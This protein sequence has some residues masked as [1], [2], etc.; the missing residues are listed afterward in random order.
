M[1]SPLISV[2]I[3]IHNC[4]KYL[5]ECLDSVVS[6]TLKDIEIIIVDDASTDASGQTADRYAESDARFRVI[7]LTES[8]G[9]GPARNM[10]M[11]EARGEFIAF[12]DGDDFYPSNDVL[13]TLYA[14]AIEKNANVCGGS[15]RYVNADGTPRTKQ[16]KQQVFEQERWYSYYEYQYEGGFYRFIYKKIFLEKNNLSFPPL[17]RFQDSVFFVKTML[18]AEIFY[19]MPKLTYAY[20]KGH[21]EVVWTEEK[22]I[23]HMKGVKEL[24]VI[25]SN[26]NMTSLSKA[27]IKNFFSR[28][29]YMILF[30]IFK[31]F[32]V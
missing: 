12:M 20:R 13:E 29:R 7:H 25:A 30:R 17:L 2:I 19:A 22:L 10:A 32:K 24:F 18:K 27:M 16:L 31:F 11:D 1:N 9:A 14:K 4:G 21:K 28:V 23:D 3:P 26:Y 15:L 8:V 6:Q 5:I